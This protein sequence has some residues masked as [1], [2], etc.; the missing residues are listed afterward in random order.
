MRD[1]R[2]DRVFGDVA[3][4][5]HVVIVALLLLQT[6]AL[7]LHLVGGLPGADDHLADT[8]HG[9]AVGRHHG[10]R[11]NVVQ[12]VFGRDCLLPDPAFGEG[13]V[14]GDQRIEMVAHHQHV[15]VL[16]DGVP[17]ERPGRIGR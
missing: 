9:L 4:G 3:F 15:Q 14:L 12:D 8:A 2:I 11:A 17:G 5:A 13:H 10:E 16:I 6:S 1:R 7:L